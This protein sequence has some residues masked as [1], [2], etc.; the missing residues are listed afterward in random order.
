MKNVILQRASWIKDKTMNESIEKA[1]AREKDIIVKNL[2]LFTSSL[3][4]QSKIKNKTPH[5]GKSLENKQGVNKPHVNQF[6]LNISVPSWVNRCFVDEWKLHDNRHLISIKRNNIR[7]FW[8]AL[9][10]LK[11][12]GFNSPHC[13]CVATFQTIVNGHRLVFLS[14]ICRQ[15]QAQ[16]RNEA[17]A[18]NRCK[19]L[20][21]DVQNFTA[22]SFRLN[23]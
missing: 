11:Y 1:Y 5:V 7:S 12:G 4:L 3:S 13:A 20:K 16:H 15:P 17:Q 6:T 23:T 22:P 8:F 2:K 9:D 14:K 21:S 18:L 10:S 19:T